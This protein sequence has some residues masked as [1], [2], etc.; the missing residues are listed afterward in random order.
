[1]QVLAHGEAQ[2]EG[3]VRMVGVVRMISEYRQLQWNSL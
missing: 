2:E 3:V 1:M